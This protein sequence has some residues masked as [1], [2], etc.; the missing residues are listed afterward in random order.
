MRPLTWGYAML[1]SPND[2]ETAVHG[3]H[4]QGDMLVSMCKVLTISQ[5]KQNPQWY[6]IDR[7]GGGGRGGGE[8][9]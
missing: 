2:D 9:E 8:R 7:W 6:H 3:C 4:Y 5:N 1:M